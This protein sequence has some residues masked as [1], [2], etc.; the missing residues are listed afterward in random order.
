MIEKRNIFLVGPMGSGKSTIGSQLSY[1]MNMEF[2][3]SDREIEKRTGADIEWVIDIEGEK[4]FQKREALLINELTRKKGIVLAT[5]SSSVKLK[6]T[7]NCIS[8]RG[9]VIYLKTSIDKQL[10][11]MKQHKKKRFLTYSNVPIRESLEKLLKNEEPLYEK[12]C[13]MIIQTD[14]KSTRMVIK[15]IMSLLEKNKL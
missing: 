4:G 7:R 1:Q 13:D 12:I 3:D 9:I 5:G 15:Q 8:T 2:Y 14:A 10:L 6:E 11:F